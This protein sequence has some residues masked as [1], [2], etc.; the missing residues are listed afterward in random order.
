MKRDRTNEGRIITH[1]RGLGT[2]TPQMVE[3]R[4]R[5]IALING[6]SREH[7]TDSDREEAW[8]ELTGAEAADPGAEPETRAEVAQWEDAAGSAG[9]QT[10]TVPVHDEQ[11]DAERLV[12]EGVAEAEH[13]QM[14]EGTKESMKR[15]L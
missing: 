3:A 1:G 13:D 10:P 14:L 7:V 9:E 4:A 6:R 11:T 12:K 15:E 2:A 5:E 8:R